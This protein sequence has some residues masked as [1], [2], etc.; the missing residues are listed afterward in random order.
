[1]ND[2]QQSDLFAEQAAP[3]TA[4]M[5]CKN[6][7][8]IQSASYDQNCILD[9]IIK[10]HC[11]NGF[12]C[13]M[14]YGNGGFWKNRSRP[15]LCFDIQPLSD[16]VVKS[17]STSLPIGDSAINSAIF[18]PP[19]ITYIKG[20]REHQNRSVVMSSRFGGYYKYSEL[21]D[22]YLGTIKE[23][24]RVLSAKGIFVF[25]CQDIIHNHKMHCTHS[26]VIGMAQ[27]HGFRLKDLFVLLAKHRMPGPQR[28]TQR[29]ARI[30]HSYFLVFERLNK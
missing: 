6:D 12:D 23:A 5:P 13:D 29:H 28:G 10:L 20:G 7:E 1:M 26:M 2:M 30:F 27:N 22:H 21:E 17:C 9:S 25:K 16:F 15:V 24:F 14:T 8:I 4:P 19:F 3:N 11:P 18:D